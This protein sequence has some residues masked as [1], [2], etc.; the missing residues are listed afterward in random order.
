MNADER[1][2]QQLREQQGRDKVVRIAQHHEEQAQQR[3]RVARS[4]RARRQRLIGLAV[5]ALMIVAGAVLAV[6][7][8]GWGPWEDRDLIGKA[9]G[10]A[11]LAFLFAGIGQ[12]AVSWRMDGRA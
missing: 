7:T 9:V 5:A 3:M 1:F 4:R 11:P 6:V 10:L 12:F 2:R 8:A